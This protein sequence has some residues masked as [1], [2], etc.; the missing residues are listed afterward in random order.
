M[1]NLDAQ[2]DWG[3]A[4]DY[5]QMQWLMLQQ[6]KPQDYVIATG[7]MNSVREF[8]ELSA[9]ELGW[10]KKD[11]DKAIMWEK[12]GLDEIG[13]RADTKE[14]VVRVDPRYFRP[15]EVQQLLG[16]SSKARRKLKWKPKINLNQLIEEMIEEDSNNAKKESLL[17]DK[18]FSIEQISMI[19]GT[20][21]FLALIALFFVRN[22]LNPIK[23]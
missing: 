6:D 11:G 10:N 14:V 21:I 22:K 20:Y 2:R 9:K 8:I 17:I 3:H 4:K 15:T 18:G 13:R 19:S 7:Q 23:I 1:G 12:S 16:D 5:V